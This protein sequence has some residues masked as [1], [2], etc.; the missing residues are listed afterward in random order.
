[1]INQSVLVPYKISLKLL[2]FRS[3]MPH[4]THYLVTNNVDKLWNLIV[5]FLLNIWINN[6]AGYIL[7]C[8]L[9]WPRLL[10]HKRSSLAQTLGSGVRI[11]LEVRLCLRLFCVCVVLCVGSDRATGWSPVEGVLP[12]VCKIKKLKNRPKSNKKLYSHGWMDGWMDGWVGEWVGG[13]VGGWLNGW[14]DGYSYG[15]IYR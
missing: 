9:E 2:N 13:W 5:L 10:R 6:S 15:W 7:K 12:T 14:M 1:M 3:R 4:C 11:P 8:R